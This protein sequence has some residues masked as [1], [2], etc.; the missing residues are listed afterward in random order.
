[1]ESRT[2]EVLKERAGI[3]MPWPDRNTDEKMR[4]KKSGETVLSCLREFQMTFPDDLFLYRVPFYQR[5]AK[6][7]SMYTLPC[8]SHFP[9]ALES[10]GDKPGNFERSR[11]ERKRLVSGHTLVGTLGLNVTR[12]L[13]LVADLFASGRFLGTVSREVSGLATVVTL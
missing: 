3:S 12:L 6:P 9:V 5:I 10:R 11:R 8:G 13:A 1:V 2:V 7:E 4:K